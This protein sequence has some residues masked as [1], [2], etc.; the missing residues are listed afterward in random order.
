[1]KLLHRKISKQ[2]QDLTNYTERIPKW[3][4]AGR[5]TPTLTDEAKDKAKDKAK[6]P[7]QLMADNMPPDNVDTSIRNHC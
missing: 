2:L 4:T 3:L 5:T 7:M 6:K 1:M